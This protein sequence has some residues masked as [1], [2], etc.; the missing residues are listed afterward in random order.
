MANMARIEPH[1]EPLPGYRLIERLGGGGFGEV[2]KA[3]APGGLHKAIKFVYGDLQQLGEE[4]QRAEQELKALSRVKTVR[5]PYILSLERFDVLD[6]QLII[7]ME[8]ADKNLWDR[9]KECR[10]S[11]LPGI[12]RD[13]LIGYM[14]ETAEA[15][16]LMNN[17]YQLQHLDIKPQNIFLVFNHIKVADFGLVKD[18]EGMQASVTGGVTPVYAAPETFDGWVSRFSDQYSMAIV[19]QELLTGQ[20]P[21]NGGNVRQLVLQ[22][23]QATPNLSSLPP[24]EQPVVGRSLA[25][26]PDERY[27]TCM[28]M[29][30]ALQQAGRVVP[31]RDEPRS[32]SPAVALDAMPAAAQPLCSDSQAGTIRLNRAQEAMKQ[33]ES[34][35]TCEIPAGPLVAPP[36]RVGDGPLF[37]ALIVGV[38]QTALRVVQHVRQALHERF[39]N[40][41]VLPH[42]RFLYLDT[43]Q[44]VTRL[45]TR[46]E[47]GAALASQEILITPLNRPAHYLRSVNGR[48]PI[49]SWC[50]PRLVYRIPRAQVT[51]GC[52]TLGRL[53]F[54]DHYR[55]ISKRLRQELEMCL[56]PAAL[57]ESQRFTG[58]AARTNR[59]RVYVVAGLGG[60]T[61]SGMFMDLAYV[62]RAHLRQMG[63]QQP[64][65]CGVFLTPSLEVDVRTPRA[66]PNEAERR[67]DRRSRP[68]TTPS[69]KTAPPSSRSSAQT[70]ALG[71]TVAA[72]MEM[73]YFG[74]PDNGFFARYHENEPPLRDA[75]PPFNRSFILQLD[76]GAASADSASG[77]TTGVSTSIGAA[78]EFLARELT[79]QLG[80]VVD[81]SR[82]DLQAPPWPR[83]GLYHST[84]GLYCLTSPHRALIQ[85][86][87][88]ELCA[89]LV[90]QWKSKDSAPVK[91]GAI[92]WAEQRWER[93]GWSPQVLSQQLQ[94]L[95][96]RVVGQ[97]IQRDA[98]AGP[99]PWEQAMSSILAPLMVKF[100]ASTREH[101]KDIRERDKVQSA[102]VV[103]FEE[104]LRKI[105]AVIG[106]PA[107]EET[108]GRSAVLPEHLRAAVEELVVGWG[109]RVAELVVRLIEQPGFRLAGAEEVVRQTVAK[110]ETVLQALEPKAKEL[111]KTV[112]E[113]YARIQTLLQA[114][115]KP[116]K[117]RPPILIADVIELIRCYAEW[118][119][120][121]LLRQ[122]LVSAYVSLRGH[123]SDEL[124]EI[125]FCRVRLTELQQTFA[126][127]CIRRKRGSSSQEIRSTR[128]SLTAS[129]GCGAEQ[130]STSVLEDVPRGSSQ[131]G[132]R[133]SDAD[134]VAGRRLFPPGCRNLEQAV[135]Q[136]LS[137]VE[138]EDLAELDNQMQQMIRRDFRALVHVCLTSTNVLKDLEQA[139]QHEAEVFVTPRLAGTNPAELFL[140]Q[141]SDDGSALS[142]LQSAFDEAAPMSQSRSPGWQPT[143]MSVLLTPAGPEGE[144]LRRLAKQAINNVTI[145]G[146]DGDDDIVIYRELA[147]VPL[148]DLEPMQA[149][150][151]EAYRQMCAVENFTPHARI[152]IT[153]PPLRRES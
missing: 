3:E 20:R 53:A 132:L 144:K 75:E 116:A 100:R 117:G 137:N 30:K 40:L 101:I 89:N 120:D 25:K 66:M 27:P 67:R 32:E 10:S 61:G 80:R 99:M 12:P 96:E 70:L 38:G 34:A 87:A 65:L 113:T 88:R 126:D 135:T 140:Q 35:A 56:D 93:E 147:N 102:D 36:E 11:G 15:L 37:P 45:A 5:H 68:A 129:I 17:Q 123:W 73:S 7:V 46:G 110:I 55:T 139:M 112:S 8:L 51:L 92:E 23:L 16:D 95:S 29:V 28:E 24:L 118:R 131:G 1:A 152:D 145:L 107:D 121:D 91:A 134:S 90:D 148:A 103:H 22:H 108:M 115:A 146:A 74:T 59:P 2:W 153:F 81:M 58:L 84:F 111:A 133:D 122:Q 151:L 138:A 150:G 105:E 128:P 106:W 119:Y 13:E 33:V 62:V 98:T 125:N 109:D 47:N 77:E 44:D 60:G 94:E 83:R 31:F 124:R 52:R 141:H 57:A 76:G 18:L 19:Y 72:L 149:V 71:N 86:L 43:D 4:G 114:L 130:S 41:G 85:E 64:D 97:S 39:G 79:S 50:N 6:G 142:E 78:G 48:P 49:D 136:Y 104:A 63:Y 127:A 21:F 26:N 143:E 14:L 42:L 54:V 9:F 82:A 69:A